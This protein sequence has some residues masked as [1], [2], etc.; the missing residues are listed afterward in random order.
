MGILNVHDLI[1]DIISGLD[2][3]YQRMTGELEGLSNL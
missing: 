1:T 3:I 2:K